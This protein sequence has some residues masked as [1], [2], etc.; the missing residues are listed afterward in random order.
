MTVAGMTTRRQ[1]VRFGRA[2]L[3][4]E[5]RW[6]FDFSWDVAFPPMYGDNVIRKVQQVTTDGDSQIYNPLGALSKDPKSPWLG[7][8]HM[9]C[10][11]HLVEQKFD[12]AV[13]NKTDREGFFYQIKIGYDHSQTT[14]RQR[15]NTSCRVGYSLIL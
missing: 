12:N 2:L 15:M 8:V 10:T 11:C 5:C 7:V 3:P 4:N 13:L 9:L 1:T 14:M 6:V